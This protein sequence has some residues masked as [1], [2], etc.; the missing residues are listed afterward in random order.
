[1]PPPDAPK[2]PRILSSYSGGLSDDGRLFMITFNR[3]DGT[4]HEI[5]IPFDSLADMI[6]LLEATS[7]K[8]IERQEATLRGQ[9]RRAFYPVKKRKLT[10]IG[11]GVS[12]DGIP[13]LTLGIDQTIQMDFALPAE[14]IQELIE[15]LQQ[16]DRDAKSLPKG[17]SN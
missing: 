7:G 12:P 11:G 17:R 6:G 14:Q 8:A 5:I 1:M 3:T 13:I 15:Y 10:K 9:D 4:K 2:D 16:L